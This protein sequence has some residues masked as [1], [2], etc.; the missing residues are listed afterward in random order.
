[1]QLKAVSGSSITFQ[2][3]ADDSKQVTLDFASIGSSTERTWTF[4]NSNGTLI[5]KDTTDT[6]TNK[7]LTAPVLN[8]PTF[9]VSV[10]VTAATGSSQG[11]GPITSTFVEIATVG[12]TG[13]AV[14]LPTAAAG[15]L[16]IIANNGA[17]AADVFP[18][19]G[20]KIDGGSTNAALSLAA[21]ANRLH[22]CQD[23]T[24]WDTIQG[25]GAGGL[26]ELSE[27]SSPQLGAD[28]DIIARG[29]ISSN[30]IMNP[31]LTST[32]KALV[33]GF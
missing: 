27:D 33:L 21:G 12:T 20:D 17:N 13:D 18:A 11:D 7:T 2:D 10:G 5:G 31:T 30:T 15:K 14:T 32:G 16:V 19:S 28:L 4:P 22:I 8:D 24:D 9:D 29:I 6:L 26:S 3:D 23:G 25:A 1:M